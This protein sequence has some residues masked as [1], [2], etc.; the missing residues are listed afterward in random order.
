MPSE[1]FENVS[2]G[3]EVTVSGVGFKAGPTVFT[4]E[5]GSCSGDDCERFGG[6]A[7]GADLQLSAQGLI[8]GS[9]KGGQS[10]EGNS[11]ASLTSVGGPRIVRSATVEIEPQQDVEF[12]KLTVSF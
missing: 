4:V 3:D 2:A 12:D 1:T 8:R 10:L 11:S 6:G 7:S 9:S 5:S